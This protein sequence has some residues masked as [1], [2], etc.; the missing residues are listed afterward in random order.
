[1]TTK[2][3]PRSKTPRTVQ[4]VAAK[5]N[6]TPG[7]SENGN[8]QFKKEPL[9]HLYELTVSTLFGK[10]TYYRTSDTLV[11]N[12]RNEVRKAVQMDALDFVANLAIHAR[13]EMNIRTIPIVLVV[14]FA[15][16]LREQQ[17]MYFNMRRLVADVIQ[18]ADQITDM[19]AYALEV[20][21]D[22]GKIPMAI[23]RGVADAFNKFGAYAFA[24]Y[25]R[26][27]TVKFKDV[28]RIVHPD[29]KDLK[30]GEI[31]KKIMEE[32][33]EAPYTW[34]VEL[35]KNG[36]LPVDERK[37]NKDLWTE[38]VVSG[39]VGY[40]ALLRNMR[41]IVQAGVE[42]K[43]VQQH[44][45]DVIADPARVAASKQLT[46]DFV[47]AYKVIQPLD[48]KLATA[49]SKAIDIST[50]YLPKLGDKIWLIIDYSGSMGGN[51]GTAINTATLLASALLK[52]NESADNLAVTLFG[53]A[54]KTLKGV[55]TNNSVLGIQK[56]LLSHRRGEISGST[57]FYAALKQ[58]STLGFEPDTIIVFTDGEVNRFPYR[59]LKATAGD[60][61]VVK[62]TVNLNA[63]TTT[64]FIKEEG[65]FTMAGWTSA[66]F[67]W[68]PAMR[69]KET[70]VEALSGPYTGIVKATQEE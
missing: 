55:D 4:A 2:L 58:K 57:E 62:I 1:M 13:T 35:S 6:L 60:K 50:K 68:V 51:E 15:Q 64:P 17:K 37:S 59:E 70:V 29:A 11:T 36:Q 28:L 32:S 30:Q 24:K 69:N 33:L 3:N 26:D 66:M 9:Q 22:K 61:N 52:A 10:N 42:P 20:F 5:H 12:L 31:F 54:A 18:R 19:Y 47:E 25:N 48:S 53:S 67:K 65:W 41:N 45:A 49:T 23:K 21:G 39:K 27:G 44:V 46:F 43:I 8:L 34:E 14:E 40:M 38:L 63:A 16:A 56:E 7:F